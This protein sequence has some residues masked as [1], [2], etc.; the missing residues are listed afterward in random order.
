MKI[1]ALD[2]SKTSTGWCIWDGAAEKPLYGHWVL[3]SEYTSDG[4][5]FA[6]L[7]EGMSDLWRTICRF[8]YVAIESPINPAQLQGNTTIQT[9]RLA[10]GLAA[11]AHSFAYAMD[12][13][14][15]IEVNVSSWRPDYI[16][17]FHSDEA[18]RVARVA[19][20]AGNS[21][22]S[23]RSDLKALTMERC[24]QLGL[25]PRKDDEADA[26]GILTYIVLSHG[27]TPPWIADEVLR[28]P[29]GGPR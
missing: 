18:R 2:L 13:R 25:N 24:R 12:C 28:Q 14:P 17:K 5:V 22:A 11:H 10:S 26:I 15:V 6:K 4:G 21:R 1:L 7:H 19:K 3:G 27:E 9:I 8:D 29:L 23:A 16:G 20:K